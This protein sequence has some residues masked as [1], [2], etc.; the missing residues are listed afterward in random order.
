MLAEW[1]VKIL[2]HAW[3]GFSWHNL[4]RLR[5]PQQY[6]A[7]EGGQFYWDRI[8]GA[9]SCEPDHLFLGMFD[10]YDEATALMPMSD[11]HPMV[12]PEFGNYLTNEGHDPFLYLALSGAARELLN[13]T[14]TASDEVPSVEDLTPPGYLGQER[15]VFLAKED[16]EEGLHLVAVNDGETVPQVVAGHHCRRNVQGEGRASYFNFGVAEELQAKESG[17]QSA[18]IEVELYDDSPG[19][20]VA[21]EYSGADSAYQVD[22]REVSLV[23]SRGWIRLRWTVEEAR[24]SGRQNAGASFRI[25]VSEKHSVPIRRV[26]VFAPEG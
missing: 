22:H 1:G 6:T 2:P 26:S 24:F 12:H 20:A 13:G 5:P 23:G 25:R 10:E 19:A 21:L 15:T 18:T 8:Q 9:L 4:K 3:P 17:G 7:R 11:N 14:R 16:R